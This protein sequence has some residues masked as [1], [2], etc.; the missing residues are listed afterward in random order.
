MKIKE[1]AMIV[2]ESVDF[3]K[4]QEISEKIIPWKLLNLKERYWAGVWEWML[5]NLSEYSAQKRYICKYFNS[6]KQFS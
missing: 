5:S 4:Y 3:A 1:I 2:A 6:N